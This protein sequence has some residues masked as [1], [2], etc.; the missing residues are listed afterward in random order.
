M[1]EAET[2]QA[3]QLLDLLLEYFGEQGERWTRDRYDDGDGRRCLVGA[4]HYLRCQ[5]RVSSERAECFLH[6]AIKQGRPHRRGGL[7][8]F[9]D[10]CRSYAELRSAIIEART[11]ALGEAERE[12]ATAAAE[13][14]LLAEVERE[15]AA[16]AVATAKRATFTLSPRSPGE[17]TNARE[18]LAA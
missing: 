15:R 9:N 13:R 12:R 11:L 18:R 16:K 5:H 3:V 1:C 10:R 6:E 17:T 8:Y 14:W 2:G 7:V 4:L